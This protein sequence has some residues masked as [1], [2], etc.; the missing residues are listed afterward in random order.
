MV[1]ITKAQIL[2]L[3]IIANV[4]YAGSRE[5]GIDSGVSFSGTS[6]CNMR[7]GVRGCSRL[8]DLVGVRE[9]EAFPLRDSCSETV[10][11]RDPNRKTGSRVE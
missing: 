4:D 10:E 11:R 9:D 3:Y 7:V 8:S 1:R 5:R 2:R 6:S